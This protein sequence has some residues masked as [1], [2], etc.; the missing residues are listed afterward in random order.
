[1]EKFDLLLKNGHVVT[2]SGTVQTNVAVRGG[3]IVE[4]GCSADVEAAEVID[5]TGLH[6]LP[7]VIDTQ[8]H[9]REPGG[10]HKE[11]LETGTKAAIAGG[12]TAIFEMPNTNPLTITPESLQWKLDKAAATSYC[13]YAFYLGGTADYADQLNEWENLKG[14]CGIKIFM[15]SSTGSLL[16]QLR[17]CLKMVAALSLCMLRMSK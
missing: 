17:Q 8:V 7:G 15:G 16:R 11:T 2:P 13:D 3:K 10:E 1:M 6:V 12:V 14:V 5:C 4:I 9:F